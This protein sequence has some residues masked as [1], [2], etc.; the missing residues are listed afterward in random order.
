MID[1]TKLERKLARLKEL[2]IG[3]DVTRG[4]YLGNRREILDELASIPPTHAMPD[5]V[6]AETL[7][8]FLGNVHEA[9]QVATPD[10]RNLIA[11]QVLFGVIVENQRAVYVK[12]KPELAPF[13]RQAAR[14]QAQDESNVSAEVTG[15]EPAISALTGLHVRP[16]HHTSKRT[17][18]YPLV[19]S[20]VKI[21]EH[22]G[23]PRDFRNLR[24]EP[25][26]I[27]SLGHISPNLLR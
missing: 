12:P 24:Q 8:T 15:F 19:V 2:Y 22:A 21:A 3:V 23:C 4:S 9:W 11:R 1:R 25:I 10:E 16:L 5:E 13:F 26:V 17:R 7:M 6:V 27:E 14:C 20:T 18:V